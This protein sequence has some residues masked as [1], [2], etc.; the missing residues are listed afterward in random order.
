[1]KCDF[2]ASVDVRWEYPAHDVS[3][4]EINAESIGAWNAC[5]ACYE[6]IEAGDRE[7]L[8]TRALEGNPDLTSL[9]TTLNIPLEKRVEHIHIMHAYFLASRTGPAVP[10]RRNHPMTPVYCDRCQRETPHRHLCDSPYGLGGAYLA[11]TERYE[12][13][14]CGHALHRE[15][16]ERL[17]LRYVLDKGREGAKP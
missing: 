15:E 6:C 5:Q 13:S 4:P 17:G 16:G 3:I 11:R 1:M 12:C 14:L 9:A 2:C 8:V 10:V 7:G